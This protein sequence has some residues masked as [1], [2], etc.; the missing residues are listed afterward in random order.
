MARSFLLKSGSVAARQF[1]RD[2]GWVSQAGRGAA[3]RCADR[4]GPPGHRLQVVEQN[5]Q[6]PLGGRR[7]R[8]R[9][10]LQQIHRDGS[11]YSRIGV[12]RNCFASVARQRYPRFR[13]GK[14]EACNSGHLGD[15]RV[16]ARHIVPPSY[17]ARAR[18]IPDREPSSLVG[19]SLIGSPDI[20]SPRKNTRRRRPWSK[21]LRH[22]RGEVISRNLL[23]SY[24]QKL[25]HWNQGK[26]T[27][28]G[29]HRRI[30]DF[31]SFF[32]YVFPKSQLPVK[33]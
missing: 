3:D 15:C 17:R 20:N 32:P 26:R 6:A 24:S 23:F 5:L 33:K 1:R 19:P 16:L 25:S 12:I 22:N 27:G 7:L 30:S 10:E 9:K 29:S 18:P 21:T 14:G 13:S 31:I 8:G 28:L 11:P 2:R 4:Q